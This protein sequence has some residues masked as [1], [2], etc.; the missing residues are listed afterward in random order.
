MPRTPKLTNMMDASIEFS[1][2]YTMG[3]KLGEGAFSEVFEA[4]LKGARPGAQP[5]AVKRTI[6]RG[7][8]REDEKGLLEEVKISIFTCVLPCGGF[9]C[10][11]AFA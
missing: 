11:W 4:T 5:Y 7:L 6:R 10:P 1:R 3:K 8:A 9:I 2:T